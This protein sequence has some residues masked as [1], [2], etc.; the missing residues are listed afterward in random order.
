[1]P[2]APKLSAI[3]RA[4]TQPCESAFGAEYSEARTTARRQ[5]RRKDF[6]AI[7]SRRILISKFGTGRRLRVL[8]E[9]L[10]GINR[11][12][13][14]MVKFKQLSQRGNL[15]HESICFPILFSLAV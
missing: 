1:M 6:L 13:R 8:P 12:S 9:T 5:Q 10:S 3:N 4:G 11:R 7:E 2:V 14:A 15:D